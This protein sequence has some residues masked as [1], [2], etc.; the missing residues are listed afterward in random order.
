MCPSSVTKT[1]ETFLQFQELQIDNGFLLSGARHMVQVDEGERLLCQQAGVQSLRKLW[2]GF[3]TACVEM[4][5][6]RGNLE[7]LSGP[8]IE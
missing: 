1:F 5:L 2:Q 4:S 8:Y 6:T 7:Q 3:A